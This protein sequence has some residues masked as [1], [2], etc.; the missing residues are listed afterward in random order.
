[1]HLHMMFLS[2]TCF[3]AYG[4]RLRYYHHRRQFSSVYGLWVRK[5]W[6]ASDFHALT[7]VDILAAFPTALSVVVSCVG[8]CPFQ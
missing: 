6:N 7:A 4:E 3:V 1:M 5:C 8:F 2:T